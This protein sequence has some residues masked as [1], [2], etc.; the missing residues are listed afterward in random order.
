MTNKFRQGILAN[1]GAAID[2]QFK[3]NGDLS[4]CAGRFVQL[5][6]V[7][8][9][10]TGATGASNPAP[11]GVLQNG[12]GASQVARVRMFGVTTLQVPA[13]ACTLTRGYYVSSTGCGGGIYT[14]ASGMIFG[15]VISGSVASGAAGSLLAIISTIVPSGSLN[16]G[17]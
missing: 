10:V 8:G 6:T 9:E 11:I 7:D 2:F 12:P 14:G 15:R 1:N 13:T 17:S 3:A 16:A 5:H 4:T